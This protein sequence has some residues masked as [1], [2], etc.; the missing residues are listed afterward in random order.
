MDTDYLVDNDEDFQE[1][2]QGI[3]DAIY[4]KNMQVVFAVLRDIFIFSMAQCSPAARWDI[5]KNFKRDASQM[6]VEA[7]EMAEAVCKDP[8]IAGLPSTAR[9]DVMESPNGKNLRP[10]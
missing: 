4:G 3:V 7:N 8:S 10:Q 2:R 5:A 6:L 1:I 9:H